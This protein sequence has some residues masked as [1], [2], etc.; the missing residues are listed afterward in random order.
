MALRL[1]RGTDADRQTIVPLQGEPVWNTTNNKLYIGDGSTTG[2]VLVGPLDAT[3]YDLINDTTPQLGG[4]LDLNGNDITG[5]GN[6]N[7][8]GTITATGNITLGDDASD[9]INVGGLIS[10]NM[11]PAQDQTYDLGS[12]ARYWRRLF[13]EGATVDG[14]ASVGSLEV[15]TNITGPDSAIIYDGDTDTLVAS[16]IRGNFKGSL[17][18]DDSTP[19][20][21]GLSNTFSTGGGTWYDATLLSNTIP[22]AGSNYPVTLYSVNIGELDKPAAL[23]VNS[24][25]GTSILGRGTLSPG[26]QPTIILQTSNG[27]LTSPTDVAPGDDLGSLLFEAYS[28][29]SYNLAGGLRTEVENV[30]GSTVNMKLKMSV[31]GGS[32]PIDATL[33]SE[34]TFSTPLAF[35]ATPSSSAPASPENGM[36]FYNES[37]HKFQGYANGIWVDLH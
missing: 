32:G 36:I 34:G 3:A 18:A 24:G 12:E 23:V 31:I 13:V 22:P 27:T 26:T 19:L 28:N 25:E 33:D 10:S 16:N 14:N 29:N 7:I 8:T 5:T 4:E 21:D 9:N 20:V 30:S 17:F 2:G 11:T 6:I 37:T 35:K 1:R 15:T